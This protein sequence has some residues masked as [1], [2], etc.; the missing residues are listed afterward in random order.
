MRRS[1]SSSSPC[2]NPPIL[3]RHPPNLS[4]Q[5]HHNRSAAHHPCSTQ[6]AMA[7]H[8]Q[9]LVINDNITSDIVSQFLQVATCVLHTHHSLVQTIIDLQEP[10]SLHKVVNDT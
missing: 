9:T 4:P 8:K 3:C 5:L 6:M 1:L 10:H 2:R 7:Q